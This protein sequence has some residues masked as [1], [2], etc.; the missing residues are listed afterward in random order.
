MSLHRSRAR[1]ALVT[2]ALLSSLASVAHAERGTEE[3]RNY[4]RATTQVSRP[5]PAPPDA[6]R[7]VT[8]PQNLSF[9]EG[10]PDYHGANGG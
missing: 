8:T 10:S 3:A 9:P 7:A 1:T 2:V 6:Q 4:Y 5:M